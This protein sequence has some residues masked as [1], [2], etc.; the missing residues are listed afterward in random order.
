MHV[1]PKYRVLRNK[2]PLLALACESAESYGM[3]QNKI[4]FINNV[5]N[6]FLITL[7]TSLSSPL[8]LRY[9]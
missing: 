8:P 1:P 3:Q 6:Y 5:D 2:L 7:S 9:H 4:L